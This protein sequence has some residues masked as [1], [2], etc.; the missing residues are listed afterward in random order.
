MKSSLYKLILA[1]L[2]LTLIL[3]ALPVPSVLAA[4]SQ[5]GDATAA[6]ARV[7]YHFARE[8][9]IIDRL[10]LEIQH[11]PDRFV[12]VQKLLDKAKELGLDALAVQTALDNLKTA[13]ETARPSFEKA[14]ALANAHAGFNADGKVTDLAVARETVASIHGQLRDYRD[15]VAPALKA[16]RDAIRA[17]REANPNF[18]KK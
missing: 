12:R 18:A 1:V 7:E 9:L 14:Q 13:L 3:G 17:F 16:L 2:T 4:G 8:Q 5:P 15:T 10:N 6:I 11:A